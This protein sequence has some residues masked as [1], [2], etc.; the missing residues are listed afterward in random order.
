MTEKGAEPQM[1]NIHTFYSGAVEIKLN[2]YFFAKVGKWNNKNGNVLN[3][4]WDI[5]G[6]WVIFYWK[7]V[8]FWIGFFCSFQDGGGMY[9][10]YKLD[11]W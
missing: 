4:H 8:V 9:R 7:T 11:I 10:K 3:L 1:K 5:R 6:Y 2:I